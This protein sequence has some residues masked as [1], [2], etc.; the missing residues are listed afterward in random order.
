MHHLPGSCTTY[1]LPPTTHTHTHTHTHT[2]K[3]TRI[4]S[5]LE[6]CGNETMSCW[7]LLN[8]YGSTVL[9]VDKC[10]LQWTPKGPYAVNLDDSHESTAVQNTGAH[11]LRI[12]EVFDGLVRAALLRVLVHLLEVRQVRL[13]VLRCPPV[14]PRYYSQTRTLQEKRSRSSLVTNKSS[15]LG[16]EEGRQAS[17][18]D[19]IIRLAESRSQ[20]RELARRKNVP[21]LKLGG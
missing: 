13:V 6:A 20:R 5:W 12:A 21:S 16:G 2:Q 8:P 7:P 9:R 4:A 18:T 1:H 17:I 19:A 11:L 10:A 3:Y 14:A 15:L